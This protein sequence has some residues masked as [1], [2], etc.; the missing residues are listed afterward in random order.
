MCYWI[1]QLLGLFSV[2]RIKQSCFLLSLPRY[3]EFFKTIQRI[4]TQFFL[5]DRVIQEESLETKHFSIRIAPMG[6]QIWSLVRDMNYFSVQGNFSYYLFFG[7]NVTK[8]KNKCSDIN[9]CKIKPLAPPLYNA[10]S[11]ISGIYKYWFEFP[12]TTIL[13]ILVFDILSKCS[14]HAIE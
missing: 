1:Y 11:R 13:I 12:K 9:F 6:S 4:F 14:E 3:A 7:R 5:M 10:P 8:T 2:H